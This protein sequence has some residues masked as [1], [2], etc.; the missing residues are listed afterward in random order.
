MTYDVSMRTTVTI[1]EDV[2]DSLKMQ[3]RLQGRPFK[4]VVHQVLRR[5][6]EPSSNGLELPAF[7][8]VV[9]RSKL[10]SG[11]N[12]LRLNQLNDALEINDL[13]AKGGQ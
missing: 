1:D 13:A 5:G 7:R 12:P 2:A 3:S 11:V 10:V 4:Q 9:N 8:V 6:M